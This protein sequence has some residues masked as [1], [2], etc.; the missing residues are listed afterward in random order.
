MNIF[1]L[2]DGNDDLNLLA[3][4]VFKWLESVSYSP[5]HGPKSVDITTFSSMAAVTRQFR[6]ADLIDTFHFKYNL[7]SA[8]GEKCISPCRFS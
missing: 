6:K 1:V 2:S 5:V 4:P 3:E 7:Q 8:C